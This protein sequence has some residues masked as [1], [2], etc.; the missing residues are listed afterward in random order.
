MMAPRVLVLACFFLA[1]APLQSVSGQEGGV[2]EAEQ[3][4]LD[5][6]LDTPVD[7]GVI[8]EGKDSA[9]AAEAATGEDV[10]DDDAVFEE[11]EDEV[12]EPEEEV[13]AN[14]GSSKSAGGVSSGFFKPLFK[15]RPKTGN[16]LCS[17][18]WK[19]KRCEPASL[20]QYKYQ[21][22][23]ATVSESCRQ[24]DF[25]VTKAAFEQADG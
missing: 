12:A 4:D 7:A 16:A 23:D 19:E 9:A 13:A 25:K 10:P 14:V 2:A 1:V 15:K 8:E 21:F 3:I 5:E 22:L 24:A 20:C 18:S 6:L 11:A 17:W